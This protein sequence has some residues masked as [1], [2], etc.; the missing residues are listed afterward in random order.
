MKNITGPS[1]SGADF[2]GRERELEQLGS[3]VKDGNHVLLS[4]PRRI[5]KTSLVLRLVDVLK[6]EG[7][8]SFRCDVQAVPTEKAF[9]QTLVEALE[10]AGVKL[11]T[12]YK[13]TRGLD[14][15]KQQLKGSKAK[16]SGVEV[17]LGGDLTDWVRTA[18]TLEAVL[19]TLPDT[20]AL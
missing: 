18:E 4:A 15:A 13:L 8:R 19:T 7:W 2:F 14:A 9:F 6:E 10:A 12:S 17:E 1:V 3:A 5:G 11:P 20:P 16:A